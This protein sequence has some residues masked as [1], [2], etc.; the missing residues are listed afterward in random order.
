MFGDGWFEREGGVEGFVIVIVWEGGKSDCD[1]VRE[2][3][4]GGFWVVRE[5]LTIFYHK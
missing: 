2:G 1:G 3:I 4:L 5:E